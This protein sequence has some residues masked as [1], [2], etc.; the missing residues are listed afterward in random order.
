M[1]ISIDPSPLTDPP[2]EKHHLPAA[3]GGEKFFSTDTTYFWSKMVKNDKF[4]EK[5]KNLHEY[6]KYEKSEV[7]V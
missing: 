6:Q 7:R 5:S 1:G 3:E 4:L 2:L